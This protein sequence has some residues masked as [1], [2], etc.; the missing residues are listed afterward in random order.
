MHRIDELHAEIA[1]IANPYDG[2]DG[3]VLED[4]ALLEDCTDALPSIDIAG[5]VRRFRAV[6]AEIHVV[7]GLDG[8]LAFDHALGAHVRLGLA[9]GFKLGIEHAR[10]GYT[11]PDADNVELEPDG[12]LPATFDASRTALDRQIA[13]IIGDWL[14]LD[15]VPADRDALSA[16]SGAREPWQA[17][18]FADAVVHL[19]RW[20]DDREIN[21]RL[22]DQPEFYDE[23]LDAIIADVWALAVVAGL[24]MGQEYWRR[25]FRH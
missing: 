17:D 24:A 9:L 10:R 15:G 20:F 2:D 4:L 23:D 3:W 16:L 21:L 11:L 18:A 25:G 6:A 5:S 22:T 7:Q 12:A 19:T 8:R 1:T 14:L 13:E